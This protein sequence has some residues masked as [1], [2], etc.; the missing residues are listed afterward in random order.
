MKRSR[1]FLSVSL[2][3]SDFLSSVVLFDSVSCFCS[4]SSHSR[5]PYY[6]SFLSRNDC[7]CSY[8]FIL[9]FHRIFRFP[10]HCTI[11]YSLSFSSF[12]ENRSLKPSTERNG[13]LRAL[14]D[15][16]KEF[17][18]GDYN[19]RSKKEVEYELA[20]RL[21]NEETD[22]GKQI[23]VEENPLNEK[24]VSEAENQLLEDS[25]LG[26]RQNCI[27]RRGAFVVAPHYFSTSL[28]P[29]TQF[30]MICLFVFSS[31]ISRVYWFD[32]VSYPLP[33]VFSS[34][35]FISPD[36][37]FDPVSYPLP[38]A[39]SGPSCAPPLFNRYWIASLY[40]SW[41]L[42][43]SISRCYFYSFFTHF[44]LSCLRF[45][46]L[47]FYFY[48]CMMMGKDEFKIFKEKKFKFNE[49]SKTRDPFIQMLQVLKENGGKEMIKKLGYTKKI[50]K[51]EIISKKEA[52]DMI[53][54]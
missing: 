8:R 26:F 9:I 33:G 23:C 49:C 51:S 21:L 30:Y 45:P 48:D 18:D 20:L 53:M 37:W 15:F 29:F 44:V 14:R 31:F 27:V 10:S 35:S 16:D 7:V 36:Y 13:T 28:N 1:D 46:K 25:R 32:P 12:L 34:S 42:D 54:K 47:L 41:S 17:Y 38:R 22:V 43:Y 50:P 3:K 24:V 2:W 4:C 40:N 11:D 39:F 19:R 6:S 5:L 52:L